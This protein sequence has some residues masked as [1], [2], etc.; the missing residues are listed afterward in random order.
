MRGIDFVVTIS[1]DQQEVLR[2]GPGQQVLQQVEGRRVD[3][4]Q[5]IEEECQRMFWPGENADKPTEH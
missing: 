5:V 1:A 2:T 3:P 4:L